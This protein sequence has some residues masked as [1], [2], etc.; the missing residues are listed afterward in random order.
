[1]N[2]L[3]KIS[4]SVS[5]GTAVQ[6]MSS[7]EIAELCGKRHD[8]V[9]RDIKK[10]LEELY[11]EDT[12]PKF[13]VSEFSELYRDSTGRTLPCYN[14]PKRECLILVSGYSTTL[15]AKI[16]DRWQEL[17]KQVA[18][19]QIDY[20]S[21]EA[22]IGFLTHLQGQIEQKAISPIDNGARICLSL[23][24]VLEKHLKTC[25]GLI[26]EAIDFPHVKSFD[27]LCTTSVQWLRRVWLHYTIPLRGKCN[28]GLHA[29]FFSTRHSF[30]VSMKNI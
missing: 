24:K 28:D 9:M 6:T 12:A 3:I 30:R 14:L 11:D 7:L 26:S 27:S 2:T 20:S 13:G 29:V 15:R 8:H 21:P 23:E 19:P 4:D 22:M 5:N 1:M 25:S 18:A 10:M 17:E 16:V